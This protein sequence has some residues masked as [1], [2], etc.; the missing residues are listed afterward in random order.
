[1][2]TGVNGKFSSTSGK[3]FSNTVSETSLS[4]CQPSLQEG[5]QAQDTAILQQREM[6]K[7]DHPGREALSSINEWMSRTPMGSVLLIGDERD[8]WRSTRRNELLAL[9]RSGCDDLL[10]AWMTNS[11]TTWFHWAVGR[12]FKA[13]TYM[14]C[15]ARMDLTVNRNQSLPTSWE[16]PST[17]LKRTYLAAH[18]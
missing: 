17:T 9:D 6:V 16:T 5:S 2:A 4:P 3:Y 14:M 7:M 18:R 8:L 10:S 11:A 12:H 15:L 13:G 1:M